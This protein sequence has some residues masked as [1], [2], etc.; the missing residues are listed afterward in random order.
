MLFGVVLA[1]AC[2]SVA[3]PPAW[4]A[5]YVAALCSRAE[6]LL[7]EGQREAAAETARAALELARERQDPLNEARARHVLGLV[8]DSPE[9]LEAALALLGDLPQDAGDWRTR[10]ALANLAVQAGALAAA[11]AHLDPLLQQTPDWP[12]LRQR[13]MAEALASHLMAQVRRSQGRTDEARRHERWA[14]LQL[15]VLPDTSLRPLRQAVAQQL[16][17]D[18][19]AQGEF[20][21]AFRQHALAAN[22]AAILEDDRARLRATRSLSRDLVQLDQL[23]DAM[24]HAQRAVDMACGL[25]D[26]RSAAEIAREA[27]AWLDHRGEPWDSVRRQPFETALR[28]ASSRA[29][30]TPPQT[31]DGSPPSGG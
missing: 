7:A 9:E 26:W 2:S 24:G 3:Q 14:G 6:T 12:D 15:T 19:A 18:H 27:L 20:G 23:T 10:L 22:L 8:D 13:A 1:P 17:D 28:D 4:D 29:E 25:H 16:G 21:E 30:S 5:R 31:S 11:E